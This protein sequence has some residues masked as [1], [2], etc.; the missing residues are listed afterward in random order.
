MVLRLLWLA[1][2]SLRKLRSSIHVGWFGLVVSLWRVSVLS[3]VCWMVLLGV[4][5]LFVWSGSSSV[6][7]V[8]IW[9]GVSSFG[10]GE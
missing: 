5:L 8:G 10:D 4:T 3:L 2:D 1:S 7:Y 6:C 9:L